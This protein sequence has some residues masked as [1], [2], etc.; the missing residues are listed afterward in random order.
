MVRLERC[1]SLRAVQDPREFGTDT[2]PWTP[3]PITPRHWWS[4][5]PDP[6]LPPIST[7]R[8]YTEVLLV[9]GA[10]FLAGIVGAVEIGRA[11]V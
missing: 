4:P 7:R 8:A 10:F 2:S 9:F 11:H 3:L 6:D 1:G 5:A